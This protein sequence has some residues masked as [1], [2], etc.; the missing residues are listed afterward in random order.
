MKSNTK[1][2]E[3]IGKINC[4]Q[5]VLKRFNNWCFLNMISK[6]EMIERLINDHL[7]KNPLSIKLNKDFSLEVRNKGTKEQK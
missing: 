6:K 4:N 2:Q 3:G 7:K 5:D 1:E